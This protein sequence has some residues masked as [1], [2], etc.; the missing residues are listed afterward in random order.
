MSEETVGTSGMASGE[1]T[2]VGLEVVEAA[3]ASMGGGRF[4]FIGD[5]RMGS[6]GGEADD[7]EEELTDGGEKT[8]TGGT[9]F[10]DKMGAAGSDVLDARLAGEAVVEPL[11][12]EKGDDGMGEGG[13]DSTGRTSSDAGTGG[14]AANEPAE[15]RVTIGGGGGGTLD[16]R[17]CCLR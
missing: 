7:V 4:C 8:G 3:V 2:V 14:G 15:L 5:T 10:G 16:M 6:T 9:F 12:G 13:T 11:E 17:P 1:V